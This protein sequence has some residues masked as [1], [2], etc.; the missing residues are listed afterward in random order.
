MEKRKI[1]F[2]ED[3]SKHDTIGE[4]WYFNGNL[5]D[6]K[7]RQYSYMNTLF[8]IKLPFRKHKILPKIP[9][10]DFYFYHS[11]ITDIEQNKFFPHIDYIV[12]TTSDSFRKDG[13]NVF[14]S[15][16]TA[17]RDLKFYYIQQSNNEYNIKGEN[18]DLRLISQKPALLENKT[19]YVNFFDRPTFYYSLTD[20]TT[21]GKI[22]VNGE[23]IEVTGKSWMDHQWSNVSDVTKDHWN[24]FS[25]QLE[26]GLEMV[27]YEYGHNRQSAYLATI[28]HPD[29]RQETFNDLVIK[30]LDRQWTSPST[31]AVYD[32]AWEIEIPERQ[33]K[34][35]V[36]SKV[37]NH[38][39]N[40]LSINYWE[41]PITIKA[42][43]NGK[44]I[45]GFGY[46][47]LAG[48]PSVFNNLALLRSKISG[49]ISKINP[50]NRVVSVP[51]DLE[52]Y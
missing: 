7:G 6:K 35:C 26:N 12:R 4:W 45:N 43:I 44:R 13:L 32:L 37:K 48:R 47:E 25:I 23:M 31:K 24:W 9:R 50:K 15:P 49:E 14:F 34:L 38:E 22:I 21:K 36:E 41:S 20:M 46:M 40:F 5:K 29:G 33:I 19:G 1:K 27:C 16:T 2:P 18:I 11:I 28:I 30:P 17:I 42:L 51:E 52:N 10:K 39:M 8:R 3:E